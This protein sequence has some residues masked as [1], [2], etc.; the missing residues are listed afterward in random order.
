[1]S[2]LKLEG[3]AGEASLKVDAS[4]L[5]KQRGTQPIGFNPLTFENMVSAFKLDGTE[6]QALLQIDEAAVQVWKF[7]ENE[8]DFQFDSSV[9]LTPGSSL[10]PAVQRDHF[11]ADGMHSSPGGSAAP[12]AAS[13]KLADAIQWGDNGG[14]VDHKHEFDD[15]R[16]ASSIKLDALSEFKVPDFK[17]AIIQGFQEADFQDFGELTGFEF[18]QTYTIN[19]SQP[20]DMVS[21]AYEIKG[22]LTSAKHD[23]AAK[24]E[25]NKDLASYQEE[26]EITGKMTEL[27][28]DHALDLSAPDKTAE[29]KEDVRIAGS[30]ASLEL[31]VVV[32]LKLGEFEKT[33]HHQLHTPQTL[34]TFD[35]SLSQSSRPPGS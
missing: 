33:F 16:G 20:N 7:R 4:A 25:H 30:E 29:Y 19:F 28:A 10:L 2:W 9:S 13:L 23:S 1:V 27:T 26:L 31:D 32:D 14:M 21:E 18:A 17:G 11:E 35:D 8:A 5:L 24:I 12:A 6:R 34:I 3:A 15:A 22:E